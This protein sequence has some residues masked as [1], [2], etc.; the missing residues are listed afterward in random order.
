MVND[1]PV[2][3]KSESVQANQNACILPLTFFL[4]MFVM[5]RHPKTSDFFSRRVLCHVGTFTDRTFR[6]RRE[7]FCLA[8]KLSH[9]VGRMMATK[10]DAFSVV[11]DHGIR[12]YHCDES[13]CRRIFTSKRSVLMHLHSTH[14]YSK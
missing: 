1:Y 14:S 7:F 3:Q 5:V 10:N 6:Q 9:A 2:N 4:G 11:N 12:Q 13:E 8:V